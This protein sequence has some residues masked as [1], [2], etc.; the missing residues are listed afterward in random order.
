MKEVELNEQKN[1]FEDD[2]LE[3][4]NINQELGIADPETK[5]EPEKKE[6]PAPEKKEEEPKAEEVNPQQEKAQEQQKQNLENLQKKEDEVKDLKA[7]LEQT[8]NANPMEGGPVNPEMEKAKQTLDQSQA[9]LEAQIN[10]AQAEIQ[11]ENAQAQKDAVV[12]PTATQ[13]ADATEDDIVKQMRRQMQQ[14]QQQ[15]QQM[16][17]MMHL[18]LQAQENARRAEEQRRKEEE[19]KRAAEE[20]A[21]EAEKNKEQQGPEKPRM[22]AEQIENLLEAKIQKAEEI[23]R[24]AAKGKYSGKMLPNGMEP[25]YFYAAVRDYHKDMAEKISRIQDPKKKEEY[26]A[27]YFNRKVMSSYVNFRAKDPVYRRMVDKYKA[28]DVMSEYQKSRFARTEKGIKEAGP[29]GSGRYLKENAG[30]IHGFNTDSVVYSEGAG[31]SEAFQD[32]ASEVKRFNSIVDSRQRL[33]E[34][35]YGVPEGRTP[36]GKL[37]QYANDVIEEGK[38]NPEMEEQVAEARKVLNYVNDLKKFGTV[39]ANLRRDMRDAIEDGKFMKADYTYPAQAADYLIAKEMM[40]EKNPKAKEYW[41]KFPKGEEAFKH[42]DGVQNSIEQYRQGFI[43]GPA[44]N[45]VLLNQEGKSLDEFTAGYRKAEGKEIDRLKKMNKEVEKQRQKQIAKMQKEA[46]KQKK[47]EAKKMAALKK[48][49]KGKKEVQEDPYAM[50]KQ[51]PK[52]Q[53]RR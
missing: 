26:F 31:M 29:L 28:K 49:N 5:I 7:N 33:G 42:L 8:K 50:K 45:T 37:E 39:G 23:A 9:N 52:A 2:G 30:F 16:Q 19:K 18:Q 51:D 43:T 36:Y 20:K 27:N 11:S 24:K 34:K 35:G 21:K 25:K 6:E 14:M 41:D 46:E 1:E 53:L 40:N 3:N 13:A 22:N 12:Q 32:F 15:M 17:N 48:E 47:A 4:L 10:Q 44:F 38:D